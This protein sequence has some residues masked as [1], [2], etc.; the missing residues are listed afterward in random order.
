M[1]LV[2]SGSK[3]TKESLIPENPGR[4]GLVMDTQAVLDWKMA[5]LVRRFTLPSSACPNLVHSLTAW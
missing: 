1:R 3:E 4:S 5:Y 2:T